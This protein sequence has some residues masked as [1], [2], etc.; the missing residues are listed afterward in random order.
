MALQLIKI[1]DVTISVPQTTMT[2]S[3]VPSGYT[4]LCIKVCGRTNRSAVDEGLL[5]KF[6]GSSANFTYR[7]LE[8]NGSVVSSANGTIAFLGAIP[9]N[10]ALANAFGNADI[11]IPNY[12]SSNNKVVSADVMYDNNAATNQMDMT[13]ILWSN[14]AAITSIDIV[15]GNGGSF[16][17]NSTATLY[18]VI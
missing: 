11:Y 12:S 5:I 2:F 1:A 9:G 10:N 17:A 7:Y 3:S 8:G 6:N 14:T 13:A 4:D 15:A 16:V 18:G